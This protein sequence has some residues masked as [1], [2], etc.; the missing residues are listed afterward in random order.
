[1]SRLAIV[2]W[3]VASV[4]VGAN[5][6]LGVTPHA[7][8]V[9]AAIDRDEVPV[10]C[11]S[12]PPDRGVPIDGCSRQL[13][14]CSSLAESCTALLDDCRY[15]GDRHRANDERFAGGARDLA[16]EARF[17][18]LVGHALDDLEGVEWSLECRAEICAVEMIGDVEAAMAAVQA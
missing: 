3:S 10:V 5:V 18:P 15:E 12:A 14:E 6:W 11:E 8:P 9:T 16:R 1:M 13:S 4:G 7:E 2:L 17:A